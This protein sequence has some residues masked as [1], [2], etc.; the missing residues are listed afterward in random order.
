MTRGV[1]GQHMAEELLV[2][3]VDEQ[4]ATFATVFVVAPRDIAA[5]ITQP[6]VV[7]TVVLGTSEPVGNGALRFT[8]LESAQLGES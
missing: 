3:A 6:Y 4:I 2:T 5:L 1:V 8:G 7:V